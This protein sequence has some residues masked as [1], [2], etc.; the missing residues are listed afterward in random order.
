VKQKATDYLGAV[1]QLR[2]DYR[3]VV[4]G[5]P[6]LDMSVWAHEP[7]VFPH[8]ADGQELATVAARV[9]TRALSGEL[10][11]LRASCNGL[12]LWFSPDESGSLDEISCL[13]PEMSREHV[14]LVV[15]HTDVDFEQVAEVAS[16][17]PELSIVIESGPLKILYY[18]EQVE[19]L[20]AAHNNTFLCT[21]N[22]CNWLGLERLCTKG[23][24]KRLLF[25]TH[26]PRYNP[27]AAM[28]PIAM[29]RL[30]WSQ[31]RDIAGNNLRRLLGMA[32]TV[33]AEY[34]FAPPKSFM[35]DAH[36][37]HGPPGRFPVPD[38]HFSPAD[39]LDFMDFCGLEQIYLCPIEALYEPATSARELVADFRS[40]APQR[41]FFFEAFDPRRGAQDM[42]RLRISLDDPGCIG[43]KIHPSIHEVAADD[44]SYAAVYELAAVRGVPILTHSWD[45]SPTNPVQHLSHP[46]RFRPHLQ[47][48]P[49]VRLVLGH[50]GGRPGAME[51]VV[52]LCREFPRVVVDLAGDYYDSG[53]IEFLVEQIGAER[54]LF[55]SDMNWIDPRA[56]LAPVL[57]ADIS[58]QVVLQILRTNAMRVY[59]PQADK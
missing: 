42:E 4:A 47:R 29:A 7:P 9:A 44:A 45:I 19:T 52:G 23:F 28:G 41:F 5:L 43:I 20:L 56:N 21:Y 18:L 59:R 22:F 25:G 8:H 53:L 1:R 50:A 35:V 17:W 16:A 6:W 13:F 33:D 26:S 54:I 48:Y 10:G 27:H 34:N 31:K 40:A 55:G 24:G 37:H 2:Q 58:D 57:A 14:P 32:E 15:L 46:D 36:T 12:V 30:T 49:G 51:A 38:E 39:W 3:R 11:G